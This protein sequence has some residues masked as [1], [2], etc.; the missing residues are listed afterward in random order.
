MRLVALITD[1]SVVHGIIRYYYSIVYNDSAAT[2]I[3]IWTGY[4]MHI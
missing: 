1:Y 3:N 4:L 2:I